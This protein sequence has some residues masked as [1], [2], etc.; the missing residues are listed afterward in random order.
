VPFF[1]VDILLYGIPDRLSMVGLFGTAI[2]LCLLYPALRGEPGREDC[3]FVFGGLSWF[4]FTVF[5][6]GDELDEVDF[7]GTGACFGEGICDARCL[8]SEGLRKDDGS[9]RGEVGRIA[10]SLFSL[11][12]EG[13]GMTVC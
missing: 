10:I 5:D 12:L 3:F 11:D 6:E 9:R 1:G 4:C 2:L 13:V 8:M 7:L